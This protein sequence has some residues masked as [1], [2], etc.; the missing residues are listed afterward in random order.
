MDGAW[1]NLA[2]VVYK[3]TYARHDFE[4]LEN[5]NDTVQRVIKGN[6]ELVDK[7][8]LL[9]NEE[10]KLLDL[11][12][13]R[14]AGPA[15]RGWWFSG[16]PAFDRYGG[17]ALNNCWFLTSENWENFIIAQDLLMLGGGV[18]LSVEHRFSSKLPRVKRH[19][20]ISHKNTKDADYIVPDSREGFN[21]LLYRVLESF[22]VT[23]KSFTYSTICLRPQGAKIKGFGGTAVG[24]IVLI[25]M[26]NKMC[27][28]LNQREGKHI[29]PLDAADIICIIGAMV[30][31]GNVRRSAIIILG[32]PYDKEYLK[33]K[34]WDLG[35][36]PPYRGMANF[37]VVCDDIE[38]LHPTFWKTYKAGEAF[39]II[40]RTNIR[41]FGRLGERKRDTG[42][43]VNPCAEATL[44]NFEPCN[45]QEI[46]LPNIKDK[47][48]FIEAAVLMHRWGKRVTC[49]DYHIP[50]VQKVIE[51]NRRV[52]TGIT[53]CL[54]SSLFDEKILDEVYKEIQKENKKY[55]K[56]LGIN[57]S[58][59]T[60]VVKPSGTLSLM[61]DCTAG[62]HPGHSRFMKRRVRFGANDSLIPILS[63]AGHHIEPVLNQDGSENRNA[64]VVEF[65]VKYPEGTPTI[66][67]GFGLK[68]QLNTIIKAQKHWADQSVSCTAKYTDDDLPFVKEWLAN[69]ISNLKTI[70][71][72]KY[73][74]HGFKQ[75]PEEK[76]SEEKYEN[77]IKN[78]EPIEFDQIENNG[79]ELEG[80]ECDGG[81]C[82]VK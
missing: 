60:T 18:G 3:R 25:E 63:K 28:L 37:S 15:G 17:A 29:R 53:G 48:E 47:K 56:Q 81:M 71:F 30:V 72:M 9:P 7:K 10:K 41:K 58:V 27:S 44:E 55:S 39:G 26:I 50:E 38:D 78:I 32:D 54:Q 42:I 6:L 49:A 34:R 40:N 1:S 2:K 74:N 11:L 13:N 73:S 64:L 43:G 8:H 35:A 76:I 57:E 24:P 52:G 65:Y 67:S 75:A 68:E 33:A 19:V 70:S 69:N 82:P 79:E 16:S 45:L 22:F 23:G 20:V 80:L 77:A 31:A 21:K 36:Y 66:D 61:G 12:Y 4:N 51:K 62:I 59:R 14:K 5:W 46:W